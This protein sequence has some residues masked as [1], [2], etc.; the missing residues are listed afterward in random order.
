VFEV[1]FFGDLRLEFV[2]SLEPL[3]GEMVSGACLSARD[4]DFDVFLFEF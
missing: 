4:I 2:P 1:G 3:N